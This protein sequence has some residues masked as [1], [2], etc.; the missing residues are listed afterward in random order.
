LLR[1]DGLDDEDVVGRVLHVDVELDD[2]PLRKP[3][4]GGH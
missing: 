4:E 3:G 1:Q 2:D